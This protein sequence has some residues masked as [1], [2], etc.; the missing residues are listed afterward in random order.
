MNGFQI[1]EKL[2]SN[3]I[4]TPIIILTAKNAEEEVVQGLKMGADDYITKPFG[5]SESLARVS[6][7][8]RRVSGHADEAKT[9]D[10]QGNVISLGE[11]EIYPEKYEVRLGGQSINLRPKEFEFVPPKTGRC[12]NEG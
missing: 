10:H 1:L 2:R 7:V 5:V 4:T 12:V 6:A 8:M 11:L 9:T 3:G